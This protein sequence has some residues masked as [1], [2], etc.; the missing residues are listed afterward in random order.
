MGSRC[1]DAVRRGI[2]RSEDPVEPAALL[3]ADGRQQAT[4]GH[5]QYQYWTASF[6]TSHAGK[7]MSLLHDT[8][9]RSMGAPEFPIQKHCELTPANA[10]GRRELI[11]R[12]KRT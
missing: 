10:A 12:S 1:F 9:G 8:L 6:Q 5:D 7:E 4:F 11:I 2:H 3:P